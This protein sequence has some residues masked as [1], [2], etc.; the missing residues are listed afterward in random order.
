[1]TGFH[2]SMVGSFA[3]RS[4]KIPA[5]IEI[6][7]ITLR[8]P[9]QPFKQIVIRGYGNGAE[10]SPTYHETHELETTYEHENAYE[11]DTT[12]TPDTTFAPN[13]T[14]Y[15]SEDSPATTHSASS[16]SDRD[17]RS[18]TISSFSDHSQYPESPCTELS[19]HDDSSFTKPSPITGV[20]AFDFGFEDQ[21]AA[22]ASKRPSVSTRTLTTTTYGD[23]EEEGNNSEDD[24]ILAA[25]IP[26]PL[27]PIRA[28]A[29]RTDSMNSLT[30]T[31]SSIYPDKICQ[32]A[33]IEETD[34]RGR[35]RVRG[36]E[37]MRWVAA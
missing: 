9:S 24:Y 17:N 16:W 21:A 8:K 14:S 26:L 36:M 6:P 7:A 20:S 30:S 2:R 12:Y 32:A 13:V 10:K 27:S 5:S 1:M 25:E 28:T 11:L 29:G 4:S 35:R 22:Y 15:F 3:R 19:F 34:T 18:S 33:E 31:A 37:R 23:Q